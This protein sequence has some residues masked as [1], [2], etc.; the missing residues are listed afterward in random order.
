[1]MQPTVQ[2]NVGARGV[3]ARLQF[4]I[5]APLSGKSR[6]KLKQDADLRRAIVR[7]QS[8]AH[9][10]ACPPARSHTL[11]RTRAC[12]HPHPHPHMQ[13]NTRT[14]AHT[15]PQKHALAR[16]PGVADGPASSHAS[17]LYHPCTVLYHACTMLV[18]CCTMLVG[19]AW[20]PLGTHR[21][22]E[23]AGHRWMAECFASARQ[24]T[25]CVCCQVNATTFQEWRAYM[26]KL[27]SLEGAAPAR[28]SGAAC[29]TATVV[30]R[31]TDRRT[32]AHNLYAH[33][34]A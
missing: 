9:P 30:Q 31:P 25:H 13:T 12:A 29:K 24:C 7:T 20:Y 2:L 17:R 23:R 1:M 33:F 28:N 27:D 19:T 4:G 18:P 11:M 10:T 21:R 8:A 34:C 15:Q 6:A 3:V 5:F 16:G 14:C 26:K 22:L 32:S